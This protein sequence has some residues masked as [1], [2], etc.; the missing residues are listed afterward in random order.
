MTG[1]TVV[2]G[3]PTANNNGALD[4]DCE[5]KISGGLL[6]SAGSS[7]M[8]QAPSEESSQ[9]TITMSFP[10]IQKAGTLVQLKDSKGTVIATLAP[11]KDYQT[12]VISSPQLKKNTEYTVY[13]GGT[14]TGSAANGLYTGGEYK[15]GRKVVT[16][17]A[18]NVVTWVNESGITTASKGFNQGGGP[19]GQGG[20]GGARTPGGEGG[21]KARP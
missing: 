17:T 19:G 7:G 11:K 12:V 2:V 21:A 4:Y 1:G 20:P 6:V 18:A 10:T 14:S 13:S 5:F 3:G 9:N 8:A 16:F 15:D